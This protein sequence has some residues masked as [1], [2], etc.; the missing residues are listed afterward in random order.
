MHEEADLTHR[1]KRARATPGWARPAWLLAC[2]LGLAAAGPV[3]AQD[4]KAIAATVCSACHGE[5]GN[6][7]IPMFPKIA[8]LQEAY[9]VKQLRDFQ[10]GRRKSDVMA[11]VVAQLKAEDIAPLAAYFSAQK[12]K[13]VTGVD[14][15]STDVGKLIYMD[16]NEE[17]GVP[18]CV[19]CHQPQGVG[20][21][22]YPRIGGQHAQYLQ[23]QLKSFAAG[24]RSNDVGRFMRVIA[25]RLS[26]EEIQSVAAYL[27]ALDGK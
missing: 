14:K 25:K 17:T 21:T 6:S 10:S 19:G 20:Q 2:S 8:G 23:Q 18:A 16:G 13:P 3:A 26:E 7:S 24:D 9:I 1:D 22:T 5:D 15:R 11:P 27:S 4:A 12:V